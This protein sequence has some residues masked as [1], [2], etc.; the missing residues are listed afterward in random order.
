MLA[1]E[2]VGRTEPCLVHDVVLR[3]SLDDVIHTRQLRETDAG[4]QIGRPDV[5]ARVVEGEG[6]VEVDDAVS[7]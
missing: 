7:L 3:P 4:V 6:T 1:G 2:P 5:E